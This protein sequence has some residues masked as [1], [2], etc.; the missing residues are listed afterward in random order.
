MG[1]KSKTKVA[2]ESNLFFKVLR[3]VQ[4]IKSKSLEL[5]MQF[6]VL[7]LPLASYASYLSCLDLSTFIY[8]IEM[9]LSTS[10]SC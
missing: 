5:D 3:T 8:K 2:F 10:K 1:T 6:W 4:L 9:L 7:D